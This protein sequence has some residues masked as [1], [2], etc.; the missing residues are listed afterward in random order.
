MDLRAGYRDFVNVVCCLN[1]GQEELFPNSLETHLGLVSRR[2]FHLGRVDKHTLTTLLVAEDDSV[3]FF[4]RKPAYGVRA[5][6]ERLTTDHKIEWQRY[7][8]LPSNLS[9]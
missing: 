1:S 5:C 4:I 8:N 6:G 7:N 2:V 3:E 9:L